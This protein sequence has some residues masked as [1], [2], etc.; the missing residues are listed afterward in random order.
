MAAAQSLLG[1]MPRRKLTG[2][3]VRSDYSGIRDHQINSVLHHIAHKIRQNDLHH[4]VGSQD[5]SGRHGSQ[6]SRLQLGGKWAGVSC[7]GRSGVSA[8]A[9]IPSGARKASPSIPEQS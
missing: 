7:L 1:A 2:V 5:R 4:G 9:A 3:A 6:L 8:R